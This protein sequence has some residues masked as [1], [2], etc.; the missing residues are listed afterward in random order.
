MLHPKPANERTPRS[1]LAHHVLRARDLS[2]EVKA[3]EETQVELGNEVADGAVSLLVGD[4]SERIAYLHRRDD[5]D[6]RLRMA[7]ANLAAAQEAAGPFY[8]ALGRTAISAA[9]LSEGASDRQQQN[10]QVP[11][12]VS[13]AQTA[14]QIVLGNPLQ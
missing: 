2:S 6:Q 8:A 7:R 10:E 4:A 11:V 9:M 1:G 3:L 5:T 14:G 12:S 13:T